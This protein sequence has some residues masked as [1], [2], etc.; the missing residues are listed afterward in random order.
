MNRLFRL[1]KIISS[2]DLG[3]VEAIIEKI[4][5][6]FKLIRKLFKINYKEN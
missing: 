6:L 3:L 5:E 2:L 4:R 1:L